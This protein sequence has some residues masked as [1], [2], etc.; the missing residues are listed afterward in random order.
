LNNKNT[1]VT[2]LAALILLVVL[3][4]IGLFAWW[5]WSWSTHTL[6]WF[7]FIFGSLLGGVRIKA[8]R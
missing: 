2:L 3:G 6:A 8:L 1:A 5:A 4:G 7:I